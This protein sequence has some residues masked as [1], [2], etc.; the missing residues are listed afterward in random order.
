[1][2]EFFVKIVRKLYHAFVAPVIGWCYRMSTTYIHNGQVAL[3]CIAKMENDYIRFFVEYYKSLHFD[4]I[5]IYDNNNPDGERFEEV[6]G[7]YIRSQFVEVIDYRGVKTPQMKAYQDCYDKFNKAYEWIAFFDCDEFLT[8]VDGTEDIHA[9]LNQ[10]K[11]KPFQAI[12]FNWMVFGDNEMLDNDGR[13][14]IERFKKPVMPYEFKT[15]FTHFPENCHVKSIVR[16]GLRDIK[17]VGGSHAPS[18]K[19]Y[20]SCNPEGKPECFGSFVQDIAFSSA[21]IRHY[22]TKTIGEWVR[23]KMKRGDVYYSGEKEKLMTSLEFFFRY[24]KKTK[25]KVQYAKSLMENV[26]IEDKIVK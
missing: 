12:H 26:T 18:N 14:V 25:E 6:I 23:N 15:Q 20:L 3:C 4:K 16:G 1:M 13:D 22:S 17:W 8:F 9:F 2:K 19:Y 24:N 5:I 7:D 11:Y 10:K 21:F